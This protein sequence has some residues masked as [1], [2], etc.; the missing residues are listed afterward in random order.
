MTDDDFADERRVALE[1]QAGWADDAYARGVAEGR[2]QMKEEAIAAADDTEI[3]E[4]PCRQTQDA[5]LGDAWATR[6]AIV[7]RLK[8][9]PIEAIPVRKD[10]T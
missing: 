2:R 4:A 8:T 1:K 9:L 6:R 7:E 10:K 5:Q 3:V